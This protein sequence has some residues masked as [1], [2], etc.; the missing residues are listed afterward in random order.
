MAA[1]IIDAVD[2]NR[3]VGQALI[4]R[5]FQ[6]IIDAGK[7]RTIVSEVLQVLANDRY[8]IVIELAPIHRVG[9]PTQVDCVRSAIRISPKNATPQGR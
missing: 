9:K 8:K 2:M 7:A 6:G 5:G 4:E 3:Q 1:R